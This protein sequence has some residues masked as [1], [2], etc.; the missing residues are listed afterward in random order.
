M[1]EIFWLIVAI[2]SL[3]AGIHQTYNEGIRRSWV[4]LLIAVLGF[5]MYSLRRFLRKNEEK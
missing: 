1:L 2:L 3:G 4:F 5:S